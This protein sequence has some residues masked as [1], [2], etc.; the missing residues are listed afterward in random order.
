M[1]APQ[2]PRDLPPDGPDV[3]ANFPPLHMKGVLILRVPSNPKALVCP[4]SQQ[5]CSTI[6]KVTAKVGKE[7]DNEAY[8]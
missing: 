4:F 2:D 5:H 6:L 1:F 3:C 7:T 8:I